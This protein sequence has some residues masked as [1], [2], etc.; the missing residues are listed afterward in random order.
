MSKLL[1]INTMYFEVNLQEKIL[2]THFLALSAQDSRLSRGS[3]TFKL[4]LPEVSIYSND[5]FKYLNYVLCMP[6]KS[7]KNKGV[8]I[9]KIN[10]LYIILGVI[11]FVIGL[12]Y[13]D[14]M[15]F[16]GDDVEVIN[17]KQEVSLDQ[18][19]SGYHHGSF[20]KISVE[21]GTKLA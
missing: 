3:Q 17:S 21:N 6:K 8:K 11:A 7:S 14:K 5:L 19:L 20:S 2:T 15:F 13:L 9:I 10:L 4:Q 1:P 18:F 16:S 12:N